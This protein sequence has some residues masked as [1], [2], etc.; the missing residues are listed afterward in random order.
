MVAA[1]MQVRIGC[2]ALLQANPT[3]VQ[4]M[5]WV[6]LP[7]CNICLGL[8]ASAVA[9]LWPSLDGLTLSSLV[10]LGAAQ[11][12]LTLCSISQ[13]WLGT[14]CRALVLCSTHCMERTWGGVGKDKGCLQF[15][16]RSQSPQKRIVT[17]HKFRY[18]SLPCMSA[19]APQCGASDL[20]NPSECVLK[21]RFACMQYVCTGLVFRINLSWVE[22]D[23]KNE[24]GGVP[25]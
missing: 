10:V 3:Q 25:Y 16:I 13:Q 18:H 8:G 9:E 22:L 2:V 7:L 20:P 24:V 23:Q 17:Q 21:K 15:V 1:V 4:G 11:V 5:H 19:G 12:C 14:V 6:C